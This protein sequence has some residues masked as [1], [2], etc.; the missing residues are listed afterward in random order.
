MT[1]HEVNQKVQWSVGSNAPISHPT[2]T[3]PIALGDPEFSAVLLSIISCNS[4]R[5][6]WLVLQ[7]TLVWLLLVNNSMSVF[8]TVMRPEYFPTRNEWPLILP[9]SEWN[10]AI[11]W[12]NTIAWII[13]ITLCWRHISTIIFCNF[14][15]SCWPTIFSNLFRCISKNSIGGIFYFTIFT[16][17]VINLGEGLV[18]N[19]PEAPLKFVRRRIS[20]L[21][22]E[23]D[24]MFES[25]RRAFEL[26]SPHQVTIHSTDIDGLQF[27]SC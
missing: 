10:V 21:K 17:R 25:R 20:L 8:H 16:L 13:T 1:P 26:P 15:A 22:V 9:L 11:R 27:V 14:M 18:R 5:V 19:I 4:M 3:M 2:I 24:D 6:V 7:P 23:L 12:K